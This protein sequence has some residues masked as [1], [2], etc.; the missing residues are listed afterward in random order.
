MFPGSAD[1]WLFRSPCD[2]WAMEFRAATAVGTST[3]DEYTDKCHGKIIETD[4]NTDICF[5]QVE[6]H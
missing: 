5:Q 2:S 4:I 3:K 6:I 1:D